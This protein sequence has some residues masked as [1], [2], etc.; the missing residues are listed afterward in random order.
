MLQVWITLLSATSSV[1]SDVSLPLFLWSLRSSSCSL[2]CSLSVSFRNGPLLCSG[3]APMASHFLVASLCPKKNLKDFILPTNLLDSL[4]VESSPRLEVIFSRGFE[5]V[6]ILPRVCKCFRGMEVHTLSA[7][8]CSAGSVFLFSFTGS[9]RTVPPSL[10]VWSSMM[11]YPGVGLSSSAVLD[12]QWIHLFWKF[13]SCNPG[14]FSSVISVIFLPV[15]SFPLILFYIVRSCRMDAV[16]PNMEEEMA[17]D[18]GVLA[19]RI[20]GTGRWWA[21]V[22]GVTQSRTRLKRLSSSSSNEG[23]S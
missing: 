19:R 18:S 9:L 1:H 10:V 6:L 2:H 11:V 13:V 17:T 20:P 8:G 7:Y 14:T 5:G 3:L 16:A 22:C 15:F 23:P 12:P 4:E 21:A